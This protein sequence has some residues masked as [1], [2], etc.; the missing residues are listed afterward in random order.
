VL[1]KPALAPGNVDKTMAAPVT[2]IIA[3]H[4]EF[5][6]LSFAKIASNFKIDEITGT[7]VTLRV[8]TRWPNSS[9]S[10]LL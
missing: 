1:L 10:L 4:T 3:W 2:V 5:H 8:V 6:E 9:A 7:F